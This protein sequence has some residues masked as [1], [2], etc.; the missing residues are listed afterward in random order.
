MLVNNPIHSPLRNVEFSGNYPLGQRIGLTE[1]YKVGRCS[2]CPSV[3]TGGFGIIFRPA[4]KQLPRCSFVS[5]EV[6]GGRGRTC[7]CSYPVDN[8]VRIWTLVESKFR[9]SG[10]VLTG[11]SVALYSIEAVSSF[12]LSIPPRTHAVRST[13]NSSCP[14]SLHSYS[15][16][17]TSVE[18]KSTPL[19]S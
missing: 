4:R 15:S 9:Q 2:W 10:W 18:L 16:T 6:V 13:P 5:L 19:W 12:T 8:T 7:P 17:L 14:P 1:L 11:Q 3:A